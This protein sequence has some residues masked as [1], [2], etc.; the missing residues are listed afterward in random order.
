MAGIKNITIFISLI[1]SALFLSFG[2]RQDCAKKTKLILTGIGFDNYRIGLT[3]I[4]TIIADFGNDFK[5]VEHNG[6][7]TELLYKNFGLS[8][9]YYP[10]VS[11]TIFGIDFFYPFSGTTDKGITLNESTMVDVELAHGSLD[12][13]ISKPFFEWFSEYPG[14]EYAVPR[15]TTKPTFPMDEEFYKK[16]KISRIVVLDNIE[17]FDKE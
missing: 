9:Y 13:Y 2:T 4:Q 14:I 11:D 5:K 1:S 12:W 8:F 16:L 10:E 7:S 3:S 17:N 15:D 6:Y